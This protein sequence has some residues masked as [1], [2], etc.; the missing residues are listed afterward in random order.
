MDYGLHSTVAIHLIMVW[1][2]TGN[3]QSWMINHV[4]ICLLFEVI[5]LW[6]IYTTHLKTIQNVQFIDWTINVGHKRSSEKWT[7]RSIYKDYSTSGCNEWFHSELCTV[8]T[9]LANHC[10]LVASLQKYIT[11]MI[12]FTETA[13]QSETNS[14]QYIDLKNWNGC[15]LQMRK[16]KMKV[17]NPWSIE[18]WVWQ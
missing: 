16:Q 5:T 14:F 7:F 8:S 6:Y 1:T 17:D 3:H 9:G 2:R 15:W 18:A 11:F 4:L 12:C 10:H 13:D